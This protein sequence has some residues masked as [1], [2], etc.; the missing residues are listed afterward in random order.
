MRRAVHAAIEAS[1]FLGTTSD[2]KPSLRSGVR[3]QEKVGRLIRCI[4]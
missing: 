3:R 1:R 2:I 4:F